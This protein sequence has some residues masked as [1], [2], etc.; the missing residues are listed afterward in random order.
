M[1]QKQIFLNAHVSDITRREQLNEQEHLVIPVVAAKVGV[2]NRV[3]YSNTALNGT[4]E[5]WNGVPTPVSHPTSPNGAFITANSPKVENTQNVGRFYNVVFKGNKLKGEIWLNIEKAESLGFSNVVERFEKG[6]PMEIS[7]GLFINARDETGVFNDEEFDFVAEDISPDHLALLPNEVGACSLEDGCGAMKTNCEC[8][9]TNKEKFY[10]ALKLVGSKLGLTSNV[11]S[12][13]DVRDQIRALIQETELSSDIEMHSWVVDVFPDFFVFERKGKLFKRDYSISNDVVKLGADTQE[14]IRKTSFDVVGNKKDLKGESYMTKEEMVLAIIANKSNSFSD[15][16]KETLKG[17][18][19]DVLK[20]VVSNEDAEPK[21]DKPK[22][23]DKPKDDK[24]KEDKE[25]EDEDKPKEEP[26]VKANLEQ[27]VDSLVQSSQDPEVKE[28]M[29][30][31]IEK[32]RADKKA[33]IAHIVVNSKFKA[34]QLETMDTKTLETFQQSLK[35]V[36]NYSTRGVQGNVTDK[37]YEHK[38]VL[39]KTK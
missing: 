21:E 33:L 31:A 8:K 10:N 27:K 36:A 19:E 5:A 13:S 6:E 39:I 24:P 23:D 3:F 2:M 37:P 17:L 9:V 18:N 4:F 16:D 1:E 11:I 32:Q 34:E 20:K 30:N 28:F 14:V 29:A 22:E 26:E 7:T 25:V 15:S 38:G 35:P 12:D